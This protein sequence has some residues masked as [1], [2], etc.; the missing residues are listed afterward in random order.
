MRRFIVVFVAVLVLAIPS[1]ACEG[2]ATLDSSG[3]GIHNGVILG[4]EDSPARVRPL[5][6]AMGLGDTFMR[7]QERNDGK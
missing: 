4:D 5:G 3:G 2:G 1:I 6:D 7:L